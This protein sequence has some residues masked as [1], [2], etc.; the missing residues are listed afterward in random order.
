MQLV[1]LLSR[2]RV[3]GGLALPSKKR[4][5]E[6]LARLLAEDEDAELVRLIFEGLVSREKMGS[7]GLGMGIAIPH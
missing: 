5:L 7:T 1:D 2:S 6:H 3:Q 4:L